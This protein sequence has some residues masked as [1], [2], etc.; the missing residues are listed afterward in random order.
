[1]VYNKFLIVFG[2]AVY[3]LR[4]YWSKLKQLVWL[5]TCGRVER[6]CWSWKFDVSGYEVLYKL[7]NVTSMLRKF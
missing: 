6:V 2:S 4:K 1:M 5:W 7:K 3:N